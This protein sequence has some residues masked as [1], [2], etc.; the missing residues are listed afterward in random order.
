MDVVTL[1]WRRVGKVRAIAALA[2]VA[3]LVGGLVVANWDSGKQ[4]DPVNTAADVALPHA[5]GGPSGSPSAGQA[6]EQASAQSKAQDAASAAAAQA[7]AAEDAARKKK[8]EEASRSVV[9]TLGPPTYPIPAECDVYKTKS[10]NKWRGCGLL[11]VAGFGMDQMGPCLEKLWDK[12]SHWTTTAKNKSSGAYGIA[13][14]LPGSKMASVASDW[15]WNPETQ[16]K[17][18]LGYIKGRYKTPC[19]AWAQSQSSGWY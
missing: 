19:A 14:A 6:S 18:G 8:E 2:L 3:A 16:I 5:S 4:A 11:H 9:R 13:Q 10:D 15:S 12:E 17:W 7:K 1:L